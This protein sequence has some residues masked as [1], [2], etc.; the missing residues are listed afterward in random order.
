MCCYINRSFIAFA[1]RNEFHIYSVICNKKKCKSAG[2]TDLNETTTR[3]LK[4]KGRFN[5]R[6]LSFNP[7]PWLCALGPSLKWTAF[8]W[9]KSVE[10]WANFHKH[11]FFFYVVWLFHPQAKRFL[12]HYNQS[13]LKE[14]SFQ[15]EDFQKTIF[16]RCVKESQGFVG[17]S[18]LFD[19]FFGVQRLF[20]RLYFAGITKTAIV[21]TFL[22]GRSTCVQK[23]VHLLKQPMKEEIHFLSVPV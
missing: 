19:V 10:L 17:S 8:T 9:R 2:L 12:G 14:I 5:P 3:L 20:M 13:F 11:S 4:K 1:F 6:H 21:L 15:D 22:A 18:F 23:T 16:L 7:H